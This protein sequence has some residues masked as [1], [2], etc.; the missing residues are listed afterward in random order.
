[1][2]KTRKLHIVLSVI[3]TAVFVCIG[4]FW[5]AK[6]YERLWETICELGVS[7]KFYFCEIFGI[8]QSLSPNEPV[9]PP[10]DILGGEVN[11]LPATPNVL[12][13]KV[14]VYFM[15]LINGTHLGLYF[16]NLSSWLGR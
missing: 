13:L 2:D 15:L 7:L 5:C 10:S 9:I 16:T 3:I 14:Q 6:S 8:E 1:M 11:I 12:W 4:I